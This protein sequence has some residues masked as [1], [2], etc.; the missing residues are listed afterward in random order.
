MTLRPAPGYP[1][2]RGVATSA[3]TA[4]AARVNDGT[5]R[6]GFTEQRCAHS[7]SLPTRLP[8]LSARGP[9]RASP[10]SRQPQTSLGG[11]PNS[12]HVVEVVGWVGGVVGGVVVDALPFDP[13]VPLTR[14]AVVDGA[15]A[16]VVEGAVVVM[17]VEVVATIL[18]GA[19]GP[20]ARRAKSA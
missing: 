20:D 12:T 16:V 9:D 1:V 15:L 6:P 13:V 14:G 18:C 11:L 7:R 2:E 4:G 19:R 8:L 17:V 3:A 10:K 5:R